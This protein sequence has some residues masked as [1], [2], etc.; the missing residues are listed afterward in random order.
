MATHLI[1]RRIQY[2][3][4][5]ISD[6]YFPSKKDMITFLLGKDFDISS[7]TFD[8]DL[9]RIRTDFGLEVLYDKF[10]K[11][12]YIDEENSVKVASFFKFL[13]IVSIAKIFSDSLNDSKKILDYVSFDD[14]KTF[15]GIDH[16]KNILLAITQHK[17]LAFLHENFIN[18]TL[19]NYQI[20]PIQL[21]EYE[22]RWYVIGIPK[23]M[24]EIRTFGIDRIYNLSI[25]KQ[26]K[27][28]ISRYR[29]QLEI[30]ETLIGLDYEDNNKPIKVSLLIE[31]LHVNYLRSLPIHHSQVIHNE[32]KNG[33]YLVDFFLIP[34][35]EFQSQ[36]LKMGKKCV[37]ISPKEF[38]D[39][40]RD[41]LKCTLEKY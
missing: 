12:Y 13:E 9:E 38:K 20:T 40:V 11:G 18:K 2:I 31:A 21:K 27:L 4:Q 5:H 41:V 24:K 1:S 25:G 10:K 19:K 35:Y 26:S 16:L 36:V 32:N 37:V 39:D 17:Y 8:R 6:S 28:K 23:G 14:S 33:Y 29:Y 34:N 22:N 7:R 3:I 15:K 30:F